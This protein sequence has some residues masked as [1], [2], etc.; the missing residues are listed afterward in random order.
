MLRYSVWTAVVL[1]FACSGWAQAQAAGEPT[2]DEIVRIVAAAPVRPQA[3]PRAARKVLIFSRSW[4]YK[5]SAIPYGRVA[6]R[7]LGEKSRAYVPVVTDDLDLFEPANLRQFDAIIFNNTNNEILLPED[8]AEMSAAEQARARV[9]DERLKQALVDFLKGGKGLAV[10]HA[11]VASFREWPEF[12]EIIG[13]RFENHPWV[14]GSTVTLKIEEPDHPVM[15]AFD[16]AATFTVEDEIYQLTGPYS[17]DKLRVLMCIDTD[18]TDMSVQGI[19]RKDGD[20]AM[21]YIKTYGHGRVFYCALGHH[22]ELFWKPVLLEHWLDGIQ[23]V[24]GDLAADATPSNA[25]K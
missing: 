9:R 25:G 22:H 18:R 6:F 3:A 13:A 15:A 10:F 17:R 1:L 5:H 20:F 14:A 16:G 7:V 12:G 4:G 2:P 23:F 24:L 8:F 19:R 21:T 11:G